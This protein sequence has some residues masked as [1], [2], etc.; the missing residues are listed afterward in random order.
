MPAFK[1]PRQEVL[2]SSYV[3]V[4]AHIEETG[5]WDRKIILIFGQTTGKALLQQF[6][7]RDEA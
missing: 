3:K 7:R 2:Q 5:L 1:A 6:L 4:R